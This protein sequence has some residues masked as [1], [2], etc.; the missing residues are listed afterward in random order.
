MATSHES[1]SADAEQ[2]PT[3]TGTGDS[4]SPEVTATEPTRRVHWKTGLGIFL[5]GA[6][7]QTI[8][9]F[10][11]PDRTY[12]IFF[13]Y[14][15]S[16]TA[17]FLLL[18]WW[19][20]VSGLTWRTRLRGF[21]G[22]VVAAAVFAACFRF[23]GYWGDF[24]P[25]FAPRWQP[26]TEDVAEEFWSSQPEPEQ[27]AA[28]LQAA[29]EANR[30]ATAD[31]SPETAETGASDAETG[32]TATVSV[33][34]L[35]VADDDWPHF[36]GP[37]WNSIAP[38]PALRTNW[39]EE[40]PRELWRHPVGPAWS[41]FA[42][43]GRLAYTQEQRRDEEAVVCYD[44]ETGAQL[45]V[46]SDQARFESEMGGDGPRGTPTIYDSR[47]YS[48]GATGLLNCLDPLTGTLIWQKNVLDDAS[49]SNI[50]WGLSGSP[51]IYDDVVVVNAGGRKNFGVVAYHR[52]TG[53]IV[54][55]AGRHQASY[56]TP[57]L[58]QIDG[59]RQ[60][61]IFDAA[62][63][64]GHDPESGAELWRHP[65]SNPPKVNVAIPVQLE[66]GSLLISSG[67]GSGGARLD[68]ARDEDSKTGWAVTQRNSRP[69]KLKYKFNGGILH[70]G[71]LYGLDEGVLCC[72]DPATE[73][74]LW[75][76]GRYGYGQVLLA[77]DVLVVQAESGEVILVQATPEKFVELA[78]F[79][80]LDDMTWN[81]PVLVRGRLLVRNAKEAACFDVRPAT[82]T[83][84]VP[85]VSPTVEAPADSGS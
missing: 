46:H 45:W 67:Y 16:G 47:L 4:A 74:K 29:A 49:A 22:L 58:R 32:E 21:A 10:T 54:W 23:E 34:H 11:A 71:H 43:V 70:D 19:L 68:I 31:S 62:G 33:N 52:L 85:A 73:K 44:F 83:A 40:P 12:Q 48:L 82:A 39:S 2:Q 64:A 78:K 13:I 18:L 57:S 37:D 6:V 84:E 56:A 77:G 27:A 9:W 50:E 79:A 17:T 66:D 65:W 81:H 3:G 60:L 55:H 35:S 25:R 20:F 28:I 24:I 8:A 42:V 72:F 38:A 15:I 5:A 51:L 61:L 36:R 7:I 80:P 41:S 1:P 30:S 26:T 63:L 53:E 59:M 69:L 75:R 14:Y 76:R